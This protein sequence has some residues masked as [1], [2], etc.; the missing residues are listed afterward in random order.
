MPTTARLVVVDVS[1]VCLIRELDL[2]DPGPGQVVVQIDAATVEPADIQRIAAG[3]PGLRLIGEAGSGLV[4]AAGPGVASVA[5]GDRVIV[6]RA[7]ART[8]AARAVVLDD[9]Q[10]TAP[11]SVY[12]WAT[13]VLVDEVAVAKVERLPDKEALAHLGSSSLLAKTAFERA[14]ATLDDSAAV[15]GAGPVGLALVQLLKDAGVGTIVVV[16]RSEARRSQ[17]AKLGATHVVS[18][19]G[20][21][22]LAQVREAADGGASVVFDCVYEFAATNR[23]GPLARAADGIA[24]AVGTPGTDD[25][26][27][28]LA[29]L[30]AFDVV[31]DQPDRGL[32]P[33][34]VAAVA[35][36]RFSH[37]PLVTMRYTIESVNEAVRDLESGAFVGVGLLIMEPLR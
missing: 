31:V 4:L 19:G 21:A 15:F 7:G 3:E 36:G 8:A 29:G 22:E 10:E 25:E 28:R 33:S 23:P 16:D 11:A 26:A 30:A 13:D 1:G 20:E 9:G 18:Q 24:V 14:Q 17:A 5:P 32:L 34:L 12:T 37:S 6:T 2:P 35:A 27:S